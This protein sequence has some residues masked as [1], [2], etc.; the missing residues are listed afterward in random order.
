MGIDLQKPRLSWNL[1]GDRRGIRQIAY[2]LIVSDSEGLIKRGSGD[3]YDSGKVGTDDTFCVMCRYMQKSG[4]R[5]YWA[6][7]VWDETGAESGWSDSSWW[8][9]GLLYATD[10]QDVKWI[11]PEQKP[12]IKVMQDHVSFEV[13]PQL[14]DESEHV[15]CL[16]MRKEFCLDKPVVRARA[17]ATAH[18]VYELELNGA[19]VGNYEMAPEATPYDKYLQYQTYDITDMVCVGENVIGIHIAPGWWSGI[20]GLYS[21]SCQ[22]GDKMAA[23]LKLTIDYEDGSTDVIVSDESFKYA[24]SPLRYAE[25][26]VGELYDPSYEQ[27]GWSVSGFD[28]TKWQQ[29]YCPNYDK[30]ALCG[31]NAQHITVTERRKAVRLFKTAKGE[32]MIDFGQAVSGK[33]CIPLKGTTG[34][35]VVFRYAEEL[36]QHGNYA[37][38]VFGTYKNDTDTYILKGDNA[39]IYTPHFVYHGFRY[40]MVTGDVEID[41]DCTEALVLGSSLDIISSFECSDERVTRLQQNILWTLRSNFMSIPTDN[42]DRERAGWTGDA[43]MVVATASYNLGLEAFWR[44]WMT[45]MRLEQQDDGQIPLVVP[46]WVSYR[47]MSHHREQTASSGWGDVCVILPWVLYRRHGDKRILEENYDMMARWVEYIRYTAE[48]KNPENIGELTAERAEKLRYIW[49]TGYHYGD[50]L[51]PSDCTDDNGNF[52]YL[53]KSRPLANFVPSCFYLYSTKLMSEIATVLGKPDDAAYYK[54]LS[55]KVRD[56]CSTELFNT[57]GTTIENKQGAQ[58]FAL[59]FD[60]IPEGRK[61][62][63]VNR[64]TELIAQNGGRLDTGF[65]STQY[66]MDVLTANGRVVQA[67]DLLFCDKMPSWLYEVG[68]GATTIWESWQGIMPDGYVNSVSF[69]QY[70]TAT[71]GDWLFSTVVGIKEAAP[72]FRKIL[73]APEFDD[74][75]AFV[76]ASFQSVQGKIGVRWERKLPLVTITVEIPANTQAKVQLPFADLHGVTENGCPLEGHQDIFSAVQLPDSVEVSMGSGNYTFQYDF[77]RKY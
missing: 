11:E 59:F 28:D 54:N 19:R 10:W 50:W 25:I 20:I 76:D 69:M 52:R 13:F 2:R 17:Y 58:V 16:L 60:I 45:E 33:A 38:L 42:P 44:R 1:D 18:G 77:T 73:I 23:L 24:Q 32:T 47:N 31:Q 67:Y 37:H 74:R 70:A 7:K 43:Q 49:N 53:P 72:G 27:S 65:S 61:Q 56:A 66:L 3:F 71:V 26:F 46:F 35:R 21:A 29:V 34:T 68:K 55:G 4:A 9:M 8:E 30:N 5:Y 40:V 51:T 15:P 75:L 41:P 14:P 22:Y 57:D 12:H 64:L 48:T 36:D 63:V 62:A 6:V 39:D